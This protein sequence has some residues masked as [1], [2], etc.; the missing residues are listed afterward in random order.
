MVAS[1]PEA[2]PEV[3][4]LAAVQ[5]PQYPALLAVALAPLRWAALECSS[6]IWMACQ[7]Q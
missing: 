4:F 1:P 3:G 5:F 7:I 6:T 2:A